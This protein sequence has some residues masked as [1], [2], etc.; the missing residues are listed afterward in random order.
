MFIPMYAS[1]CDIIL[2]VVLR[3]FPVRGQTKKK[4]TTKAL[5]EACGVTSLVVRG[6]QCDAARLCNSSRI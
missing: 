4:I 1:F 5:P 3:A 2:A 6:N